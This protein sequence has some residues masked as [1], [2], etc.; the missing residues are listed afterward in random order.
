MSS[1]RRKHPPAGLMSIGDALLLPP[2]TED[3]SRVKMEQ[4]SPDRHKGNRP[5]QT[6]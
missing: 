2:F 3:K 1:D 6:S 5:T 4:D